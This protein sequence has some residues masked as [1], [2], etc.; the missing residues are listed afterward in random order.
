MATSRTAG[1]IQAKL[2]RAGR[3]GSGIINAKSPLPIAFN[4]LP[5][6]TITQGIAAGNNGPV[7][8][9]IIPEEW[10]S[11]F[12]DVTAISRVMPSPV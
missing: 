8:L 12:A 9:A 10:D 11:T 2:V 5:S 7:F 3:D 4:W 1:V 6:Q